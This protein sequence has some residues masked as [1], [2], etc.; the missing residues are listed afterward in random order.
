MQATRDA[1]GWFR[2]FQIAHVLH[3]IQ[4]CIDSDKLILP[5]DCTQYRMQC[6]I[7]NS[8]ITGWRRQEFSLGRGVAHRLGY[9]SS[10]KLKQFADIVYRFW[11]QKWSQ[12]ETVGSVDTLILDQQCMF[13]GK[14]HFGDFFWGGRGLALQACCRHHL[15]RRMWIRLGL[16]V[17]PSVCLW[18]ILQGAESGGNLTNRPILK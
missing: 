2:C 4:V 16:F 7:V 12:S 13:H 11:L 17:S 15:P 9:G 3:V 10:Q 1:C 18:T 8:T 14:R 6:S 5:T